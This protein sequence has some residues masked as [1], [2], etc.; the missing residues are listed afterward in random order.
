M[1]NLSANYER[2][3]EVLRKISPDTLL[4]YQRRT[5]QLK[6]LELISLAL[7]AEFMG[8]DSENHLFRQIPNTIKSKIERSVYNRR[9][10]RLATVMNDLRLKLAK[11]F[12]EYERFFIIDSMPVEVCKLARSGTSKICKDDQYCFPNRG[13]CASQQMHFYGYKLHAVCSVQGVFQSIDLSPASVHDIHYL[14]DIREQLSDCTLLGDKGY[15]SSEVQLD[16]FNYANIELE[17]P[18]RINQKDYK[19]QFYLFKK[20]RKRIET[21]F[22]QLCDQFMIR[23]NYAKSFEGFKARLI[24]KITALTTVQFINK[25]YF[26]RNINN[27]KVSII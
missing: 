14:K 11:T 4:S 2:I 7:T 10:R 3:L 18:K 24:A 26:N 1:N 21:L 27:L 8:I 17:T 13:F 23:R 9:K 16:L 6:D 19:P 25:T 12:N 22:S 20:Q 15:L 5:P